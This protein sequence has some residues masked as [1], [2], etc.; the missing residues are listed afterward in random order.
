MPCPHDPISLSQLYLEGENKL[1][2]EAD[3][4]K[5]S[6]HLIVLNENEYFS[7]YTPINNKTC[8]IEQV[9]SNPV[10]GRMLAG[11]RA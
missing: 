4:A 3:A 5:K 9:K 10:E 8:L 11:L 6:T 2:L 1:K 7:N